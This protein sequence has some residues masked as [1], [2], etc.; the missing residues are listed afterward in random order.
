MFREA[1]C[2]LHVA[3]AESVFTV[4]KGV[5]PGGVRLIAAWRD[6]DE[7]LDRTAKDAFSW[8][9]FGGGIRSVTVL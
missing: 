5:L 7:F 3:V 9:E 2:G 4:S 8:G 6:R 1:F